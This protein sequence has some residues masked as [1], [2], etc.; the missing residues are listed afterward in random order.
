MVL[1]PAP[2]L[3]GAEAWLTRAEEHLNDLK[4]LSEL[5]LNEEIDALIASIHFDDPHG[6]E[7]SVS[8]L[9]TFGY[10][11]AHATMSV[12]AS[13]LVG[14]IIQALRRALDYLTYELA[15]LDSGSPQDDTQ[16][17]IDKRPKT[18]W[19]RCQR[20]RPGD[21]SCFL[22][23]IDKKHATAIESL[24]PYKGVNWTALLRTIS[25]P[26]K[27][28]HL[29]IGRHRTSSNVASI[30]PDDGVDREITR[31]TDGFSVIWHPA[32]DMYMK[33]RVTVYIAFEDRTRVIETLEEL[34]SKIADVLE[35]FRPCFGSQCHH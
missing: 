1:R 28:R 33:I 14:E 13:I 20:K 8:M 3:D 32:D 34:E 19:A 35:E 7:L 9:P 16:F 5:L 23:G 4:A 17:P 27:H 21:H 22:I 25:N 26:D 30:G 2:S 12:R 15:W 31:T 10:K 24:Q 18:F 11:G 6:P 29:T